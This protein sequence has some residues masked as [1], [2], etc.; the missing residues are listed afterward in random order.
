MEREKD[1]LMTPEFV[2]MQISNQQ[3]IIGKNPK[4]V[5]IYLPT[6]KINRKKFSITVRGIS[7]GVSKIGILI[8][9]LWEK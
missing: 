6:L 3:F 7:F 8:M 9:I 4:I 2:N 1:I 5:V